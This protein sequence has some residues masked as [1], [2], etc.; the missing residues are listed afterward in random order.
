MPLGC[1]FCFLVLRSADLAS[2]VRSACSRLL[3]PGGL[4]AGS[5]RTEKD[6]GATVEPLQF[7]QT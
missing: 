3:N 5:E 2:D 1:F 7:G 6:A 4:R